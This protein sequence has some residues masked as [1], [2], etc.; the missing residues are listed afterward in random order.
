MRA[1]T[2]VLFSSGSRE[3][4]DRVAP[5]LRAISPRAHYVG[6]FGCGIRANYTA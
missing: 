2:A 6:G 4:H 3:A 5:V 1:G